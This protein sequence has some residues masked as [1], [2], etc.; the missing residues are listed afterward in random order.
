MNIIR[1]L[2]RVFKLGSIQLADPDPALTPEKVRDFYSVNYPHLSSAD[3]E[4]PE[5]TSVGAVYTY[6]PAPVKTKG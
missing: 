2:P 5:V 4:G 1:P 6:L 3:W